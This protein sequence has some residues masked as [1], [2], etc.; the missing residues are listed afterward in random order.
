MKRAQALLAEE[1]ESSGGDGAVPPV[2]PFPA[3]L[4]V[5]GSS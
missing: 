4:T 2:P 5:N 3:Q 1:D